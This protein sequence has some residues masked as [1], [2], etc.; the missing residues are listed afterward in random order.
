[1]ARRVDFVGFFLAVTLAAQ[2]KG[3]DAEGPY[4][5]FRDGVAFPPPAAIVGAPFD[6][7]KFFSAPPPEQNAAPLYLDALWEF[8]TE[9]SGCFP[10]GPENDARQRAMLARRRQEVEV[11]IALTMNPKS[12]PTAEI[13]AMLANYDEGFRKLVAA[14][15]R[16]H[17]V[18]QT[19]VGITALL[20]HVQSA[21]QV[22]RVAAIKIRR[23]LE[24]GQFDD[25]IDDVKTVLRLNRDL[26]K[27]GY[28]ITGLV[29]VAIES[30]VARRM[31]EPILAAP[32]LTAGHCD[33]LI[34]VLDEYESKSIDPYAESVAMEYV[35]MR[36]TLWDL[37]L[38]QDKLAKT[39][40]VPAGAS[41][42]KT[43]IEPM[44]PVEFRKDGGPAPASKF[45]DDIDAMVAATTP[46][47]L[48]KV[49]DR[50]N[51]YFK[52]LYDLRGQTRL[53]QIR[54]RPKPEEFFKTN[55][56]LTEIIRAFLQPSVDRIGLYFGRGEA[57]FRAYKALIAI[58]RW[59][60]TH[61]G[62]SPADLDAACKAAGLKAAPLDSFDGKPLR[63][64]TLDGQPVVYSIGKDGNDDGGKVDSEFDRR[65]GDLTF[66]LA[67]KK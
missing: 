23:E 37:I 62:A 25:A 42:V 16:E 51:A 6:V 61:N 56:P 22:S 35:S 50:L 1:M 55:D 12:V 60:L 17:C 64:V 26:Q 19:G 57:T 59:Q 24:R 31:V 67:A 40:F 39:S 7:V 43:L 3:Q 44:M 28:L 63:Y 47:E 13:D 20:P 38:H 11:E 29:V 9:M 33:F 54:K 65:P 32:G 30:V 5:R 27:R 49:V 58:R 21:R 15:V 8:G 48:N 34:A 46:D 36:V 10:S 45:P 18:F 53:E 4:P 66:R 14:Q 41:V 2:S 52:A